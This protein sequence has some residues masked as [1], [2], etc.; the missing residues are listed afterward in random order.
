MYPI[1]S[2]YISL[3]P[4]DLVAYPLEFLFPL[5]FPKTSFD[6]EIRGDSSRLETESP[7]H[8]F[9]QFQELALQHSD[10]EV[11]EELIRQHLHHLG[12]QDDVLEEFWTKVAPW[13]GANRR[14]GESS[15]DSL[16]ME[17]VRQWKQARKLEHAAASSANGDWSSLAKMRLRARQFTGVPA[18]GQWDATREMLQREAEQIDEE[19]SEP[20]QESFWALLTGRQTTGNRRRDFD[21][22][23]A[24]LKVNGCASPCCFLGSGGSPAVNKGKEQDARPPDSGWSGWWLNGL[25]RNSFCRQIGSLLRRLASFCGK[26]DQGVQSQAQKRRRDEHW[27]GVISPTREGGLRKTTSLPS[28]GILRGETSS[29]SSTS[30]RSHRHLIG[31]EELDGAAILRGRDIQLIGL[32][33]HLAKEEKTSG[34]GMNYG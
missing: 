9:A 24:A 4:W 27:R 31:S 21:E 1:N 32:A 17:V 8:D 12:V 20:P 28:F 11:A 23:M 15:P 26:G 3:N 2:H 18:D 33:D 7:G 29:P 34:R 6:S 16:L 5:S 30:S 14:S 25:K 13:V 19:V 22:E 10:Q